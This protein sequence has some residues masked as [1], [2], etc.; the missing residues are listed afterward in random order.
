[1]ARLNHLLRRARRDPTLGVVMRVHVANLDTIR[2]QY[3][4]EAAEAATVRAAECVARGAIEGDTVARE[5][6][7]D[8]VLVL[9]GQVTARPDGRDRPQHHRPRP[10]VLTP[11]A[12]RR[13]A[14]LPRGRG[15]R[16]IAGCRCG[17]VAGHAGRELLQIAADPHG[18]A[19]RILA[20]TE[21][22]ENLEDAQRRAARRA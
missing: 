4:R 10:E 6:R 5:Q 14:A 1:M 9:E 12:A 19:M 7:G 18:K 3:G 11:A 16:A 21:S 2:E 8:L 20:Q 22:L 17:G 15:V 13:D